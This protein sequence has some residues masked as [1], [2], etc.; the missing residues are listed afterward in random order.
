MRTI[1][2]INQ[3]TTVSPADFGAV[4]AA[5]QKQFNQHFGP[6]WG[7]LEVALQ[8]VVGGSGVSAPA[9]GET[10][11]ILDDSDQAGALG[12]HEVAAGDFP[13][14]F[15]FA[16]TCQKAG[17]SWSSC[18]SHELL[19]Q[20]A[21]PFVQTTC[22]V[23]A[24]H[25]RP[26]V[27]AYEVC[28]PVEDDGYKIDGVEVSNFVLPSWFQDPKAAKGPFD[29]LGKLSAPLAMTPGGYLSYTTD[30]KHWRQDVSEAKART[31]RL[32]QRAGQERRL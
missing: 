17:T 11:Y 9:K 2:I 18:L 10:I 4:V 8:A 29:Y 25:G 13:V 15:V 3:A 31:P 24:L 12:Y 26:A 5:C 23:S 7:G 30:L 20:G 19:E 6:A 21:D 14:G 32:Y 27:I 28:D 1:T 16:R 22:V